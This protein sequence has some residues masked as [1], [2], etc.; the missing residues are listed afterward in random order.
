M[1]A[2][3]FLDHDAAYARFVDLFEER[4]PQLVE[5]TTPASLPTSFLVLLVDGADEAAFVAD[6]RGLPSV[7][8]VVDIRRPAGPAPR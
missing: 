1:A 6:A 5:F 3:H 7:F 2:F 8:E 4:N